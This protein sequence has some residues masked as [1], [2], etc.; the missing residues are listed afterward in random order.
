MRL[1]IFLFLFFGTSLLWGQRLSEKRIARQLQKI[2]AFQKAHLGISISTLEKGKPVAA[3]QATHYMTPASNTKLLTFLGAIQYFKKLPAV[4]YFKEQD[5][6]FHFKSTGYPLL[7]HPFYQDTL[8]DSFF[9]QKG[10]WIYHVNKEPPKPLGSG[11]AWDDY[12]YYY[13]AERSRF[14][15][16]GNVVQ[17]QVVEDTLKTVPSFFESKTVLDT[18]ANAWVRKHKRNQ[19]YFNPKAWK[20]GDTLYRPFMTSD[21]LFTK[22]LEEQ[23]HQNVELVANSKVQLEWNFLY[24]DQEEMLYKALLQDSDN[25]IAEALLLMISQQ[26]FDTMQSDKAIALLL[27]QWNAWLPDAVE[28]VDGSGV[29]RYNMIT[30]RTLV[31]VLQKIYKSVGWETIQTYFPR[32]ASSGTLKQYTHSALYAKTGTLRHNHNLSGYWVHPKGKIYVFSIMVNHHTT[33]TAEVRKGIGLLMEWL[34]RKLR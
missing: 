2:E 23:T 33:S 16:F 34:E 10:L 12:S 6:I 1:G 11:W 27:E 20:T 22:L 25:G 26:N 13:A 14:P 5:S 21:S 3:Y 4:S 19:F 30:P 9:N 15:L 32:G 31:R 29:S 28:W 7:F 18:T 24:T 17:A 8:L